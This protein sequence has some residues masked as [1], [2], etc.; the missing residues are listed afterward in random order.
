MKY[1]RYISLAAAL[2]LLSELGANAQKWSVS[3]NALELANLGT[4]NM[5]ASYAVSQHWSLNAGARYN[6]FTFASGRDNQFQ[7]RKRAVALGGRW[8]PWHVWSGW[9]MS[10]KL[11]GLEYNVG[12][13]LSDKTEEGDSVGAGFSA[14]YTYMINQH[15]NFEIGLGAWAGMKWYTVYSCPNCG[16]IVERGKRMFA[17]PDDL[18]LSLCYVF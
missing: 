12:G 10:A 6:P 14:G 13:I 18:I 5:E 3:T 8:W 17:L 11:Q 4:L 9:W 7:N 2:I 15:F 1:F 16:T